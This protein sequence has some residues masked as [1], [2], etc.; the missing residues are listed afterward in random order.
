M[1][2]HNRGLR[3]QLDRVIRPCGR[4]RRPLRLDL[5]Q[6]GLPLLR[7]PPETNLGQWHPVNK[8]HYANNLLLF[9]DL[10]SLYS[11]LSSRGKSSRMPKPG[12][13]DPI[14]HS[15]QRQTPLR[16]ASTTIKYIFDLQ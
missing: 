13:E 5:R 2:S 14:G 15:N 7:D 11:G 10:P 6:R 3:H 12:S 8:R 1:D 16:L 9:R 4:Y